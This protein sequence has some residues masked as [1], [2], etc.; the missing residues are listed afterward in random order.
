MYAPKA[1][2]DVF[3]V[4]FDP[5]HRVAL[6]GPEPS[7]SGQPLTLP[8][9]CRRGPEPYARAAGRLLR[10]MTPGR[11]WDSTVRLGSVTGRI[12]PA[13]H[14]A[15]TGQLA[16]Q[17]RLFTAHTSHA[18][19]LLPPPGA[20]RLVWLPYPQAASHLGHLHIPGLG[21]FLEGYVDGWIPDGW[22]TLE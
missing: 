12:P 1:R 10:T 19:S 22:I 3:L 17:R 11:D 20:T 18:D 14:G 2:C 13:A 21:L 8:A 16:G 7:T 6:V 9:G 5:Q 4:C 15:G